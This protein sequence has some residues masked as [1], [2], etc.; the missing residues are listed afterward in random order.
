MME[1][2]NADRRVI[3]HHAGQKHGRRKPP[4]ARLIQPEPIGLPHDMVED[5]MVEDDMGCE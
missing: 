1:V 2:V 3:F 5:D 4:A